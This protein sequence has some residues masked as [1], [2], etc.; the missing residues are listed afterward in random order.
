MINTKI[1]TDLF[2][3]M[4]TS[5]SVIVYTVSIKDATK[6]MSKR[7]LLSRELMRKT[8]T[9]YTLPCQKYKYDTRFY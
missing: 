6:E 5:L 7:E 9:K 1:N 8:D 4:I 3:N 2:A